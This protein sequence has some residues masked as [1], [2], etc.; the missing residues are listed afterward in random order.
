V[1]GSNG[2]DGS[3]MADIL[4]RRGYRVIGIA[5]QDRSRW[6]DHPEFRHV[7][8]DAGDSHQLGHLLSETKPDRIFALAAVHGAAGYSYEANW[9]EC[10][11]VNTGSVHSC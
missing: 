8:L 6:V 11:A 1:I 9:R 10:L 3:Y 5:R 4:L 7:K 2:Q